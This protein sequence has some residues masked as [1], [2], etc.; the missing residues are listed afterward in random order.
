MV[1]KLFSFVR[2]PDDDDDD[3]SVPEPLRGCGRS[4]YISISTL[5]D[6]ESILRAQLLPPH[7]A[8]LSSSTEDTSVPEAPGT[9]VYWTHLMG[10]PVVT[11]DL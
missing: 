6:P 7:A 4:F 8:G 5:M 11:G 2:S 10:K 9:S 3:D 1:F